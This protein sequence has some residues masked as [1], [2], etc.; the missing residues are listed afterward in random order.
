MPAR[1]RGDQNICKPPLH[2]RVL[3]R[4]DSRPFDERPCF[5]GVRVAPFAEN[6]LDER[7]WRT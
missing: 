6:K 1:G 4:Y 7:C 2:S 5:E 3:Q